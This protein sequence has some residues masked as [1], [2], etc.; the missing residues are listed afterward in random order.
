V[1]QPIR[2]KS[3][4]LAV[5][6]QLADRIVGGAWQAG[7]PLPPERSLCVQLGVSRT[8]VREALARLEQ[9]GLVATR[10]G[11]E[12]TARDFRAT[13]GLD[14]LPRV[15]LDAGGRPR[16]DIMHG[17][18]EMRAAVAPD[19]ARLCAE[20]ADA[21]VDVELDA[22]LAAM[23]AAGSDL[24]KLQELS[25]R[26]WQALTG[27]SGNL[28]YQLAFNSLRDA[29]LRLREQVAVAMAEELRH[30][31][32]YRAIAAAVRARDGSA[33][34]SAAR[35]HIQRGLAPVLALFEEP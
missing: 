13:A 7:E 16:R 33:A 29:Y 24:P 30:L 3:L 31:E 34:E 2:K 4:A 11:G 15:A 25:M 21:A 32:G 22:V 26:F 1:L 35:R 19:I 20:R 12:T 6:D 9:V 18:V 8:A 5:F 17:V 23:G 10:H 28:A 27:G 14:L